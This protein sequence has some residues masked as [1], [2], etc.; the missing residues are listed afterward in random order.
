VTPPKLIA[1]VGSLVLAGLL[2]ACGGGES[3][4]AKEPDPQQAFLQSMV[5]HH[6]SAVDMAAVAETEGQS[7]FVKDLARDI[8][9]TQT[10]EIDQMEKIHQRLFNAP[11]K[12]DMNA[13]MALGLS[14]QEAGMDHMDAA[15]MIRGKKPFDRV[16][17]DEMIPHHRGAIRMAEAVLAETRDPELR[18]LAENVVTAQKREI[19]EMESFRESE[20]ASNAN[21]AV[22]V[23]G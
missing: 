11:L 5:P 14:A 15:A 23:N 7:R 1:I 3:A 10:E 13:H 17:V 12:P 4:G 16:F 18:K 9:R 8:T 21:E 19:A 20:Y 6:N 2:G 22:T